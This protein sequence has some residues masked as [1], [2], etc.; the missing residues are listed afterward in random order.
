MQLSP[1]HAR[2]PK[3]QRDQEE[4]APRP[5]APKRP[6]KQ[7][8]GKASTE[9]QQKAT[10]ADAATTTV[11]SAPP[12]RSKVN[13]VN[14]K[15]R[16]V[17]PIEKDENGNPKL[18]Q[19]IGVS[20][21]LCLGEI[22]TDRKTFHNE[23]Y[24]FPVG[25]KVQRTYP[26]MIH[27][28]ANTIVTSTI[29]DGGEGPLFHISAADQPE[30][31]IVANSATGAWTAVVRKANEIRKRDHSNSASGPDYYG[32]KH[33]TIAKMIQDLPGAKKLPNY[34]W[35]S[36]EEMEPKAAKGVMA[37]AQKKRGNLEIMGN[38]NRKTPTKQKS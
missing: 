37:A 21:I 14:L 25:Y 20:T 33:P 28:D 34:L 35:Q 13:P 5:K 31:P 18:P 9:K 2:V 7:P 30:E 4:Q 38:A 15:T 29:L 16:R 32:F 6:K 3:R 12:K 22:V 19:N 36:F 1:P 26:S 17:Q 27:P 10:A 8:K 23:R 24:I 11:A